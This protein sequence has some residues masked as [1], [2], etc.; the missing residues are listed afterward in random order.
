MYSDGFPYESICLRARSWPP[1]NL[2]THEEFVTSHAD[3][4]YRE[5]LR[6]PGDMVL[7]KRDGLEGTEIVCLLS[8]TIDKI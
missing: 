2:Y 4:I 5:N 3:L 7:D 6:L 8:E 1:Y